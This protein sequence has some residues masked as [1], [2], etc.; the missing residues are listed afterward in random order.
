MIN[1]TPATRRHGSLQAY[2]RMIVQDERWPDLVE[3]LDRELFERWRAELDPAKRGA[4]HTE[5]LGFKLFSSKIKVLA[6]LNTTSGD[7]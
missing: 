3:A 1:Q 5:Y 2:A 4:I 6:T 7:R